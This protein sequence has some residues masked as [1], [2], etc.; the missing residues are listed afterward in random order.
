MIELEYDTFGAR[1]D[2]PLL[3]I[4]GLGFQLIHWDQAFC[5]RLADRGFYVIRF[6]NRDVGLSPKIRGGPK[7]NALAAF[8]GFTGSASYTLWDMADDTARLLDRLDLP[9]AH[10]VGISM[11]GMIAQSLAIKYPERVLSLASLLSTTGNRRVGMPRMRA[12]ALLL[13]RAPEER[14]AY[15]DFSVEVAKV[16]GSRKHMDEARV[17]A[18]A[19]AAYDR[20][21]YRV[22]ML[23]QL[24]AVQA[25]GDRTEQLGRLDVPT[26]VIHGSDD[27]LVPT[28]A[29]HATARAIPG[30]RMVEIA[31]LAHDLPPA[32]WDQVI[33]AIVENAER[34]PAAAAR[35]AA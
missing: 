22:G 20:C 16:I 3:L 19:G 13:K 18:V 27:P 8:A 5:R 33:E 15:I 7:P 29:G 14:E 17:R 35:A 23:R 30:A 26:V 25:S 24:V 12:L 2:P 11:G 1:S 34:S 28:R 4:M 9:A 31:G 6:D 21:H 10:V 32:V